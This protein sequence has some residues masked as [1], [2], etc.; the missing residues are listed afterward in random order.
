M[1]YSQLFGKTLRQVPKEAEAISHQLLTRG[2]F[3]DRQ[4]TAGVYSLLPLGWR[5][6]KKIENIIREEMNAIG[7]Q[8]LFLP[9]L[10]PKELWLR[11]NRWD[12][13][14]PPLF[15]FKDRHEKELTIAPTHEEVITDLA[16]RMINSY[17]DLPLAIYQIQ[18][19][20]RNE[21]RVNGGLLRVREF[22]M[23]DLYS[24][25]S[26]VEDLDQYYLEV[27]DAYKNIFSR[28]GFHAK[29]VESSS[30]TIGGDQSNEF[31][32]IC[33]TGEDTI[34]CCK[35]CDWAAN[36]EKSNPERCPKCGSDIERVHSIENGHAFKLGTKYA[37]SMGAFFTDESGHRKPLI[38]G[39][40]G[41]GLGRLM[42]TVVEEYHDEKGIL[43]PQNIAPYLVDLIDLGLKERGG[44]IYNTLTRFGAEVLWD[45]RDVTAGNKF[46]D[47]DLIGLPIRLV[48]SEKSGDLVE[49]K[50]R[51]EQQTELLDIEQIVTRLQAMK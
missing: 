14:D 15:K 27:I 37:E 49:I 3:I 26:S 28:C 36:V 18:N 38:M 2:G 35:T 16:S 17:R 32:M 22:M 9:A 47:A 50:R 40:Y 44:E 4:L 25:H 21:M 34:V 45:D 48:V 13:M 39:C 29:I 31:Q 5:V 30:G 11:S 8:E 10:Q 33:E 43:W 42:A 20:F 7:G 19:K 23:K 46:A 1:R 51:D 12:N 41:I 24:F 6:Y